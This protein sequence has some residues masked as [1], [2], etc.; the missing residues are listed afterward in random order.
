MAQT[1]ARSLFVSMPLTSRSPA[2]RVSGLPS[3]HRRPTGCRQHSAALP[4]LRHSPQGLGTLALQRRAGLARKSACKARRGASP[5]DPLER[6]SKMAGKIFKER[7]LSSR[8]SAVPT[9]KRVGITGIPTSQR[10]G[11]IGGRVSLPPQTPHR[12][13]AANGLRAAPVAPGFEAQPVTP[14]A[15]AP[16]EEGKAF[17]HLCF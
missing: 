4:P 8:A 12:H 15:C 7:R 16:P 13:A 17:G 3:A 1:A 9:S 10:A 2:R 14:G 11:H 6:A 5:P